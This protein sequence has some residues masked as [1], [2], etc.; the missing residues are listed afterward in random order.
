VN[1]HFGVTPCPYGK[2]REVRPVYEVCPHCKKSVESYHSLTP[3]RV[4]LATYSCHDHG[5]VVPM[6]SAVVNR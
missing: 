6:R 2:S 5:D 4:V 1:P 3:D